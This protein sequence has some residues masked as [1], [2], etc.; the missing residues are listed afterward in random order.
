MKIRSETGRHGMVRR[1]PA[2]AIRG[3]RYRGGWPARG[4]AIR[5]QSGHQS[6]TPDLFAQ[7]PSLSAMVEPIHLNSDRPV[8]SHML[9]TMTSTSPGSITYHQQ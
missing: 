3:A 5:Y 7:T 4:R 8:G 9:V 2:P 1:L 6:F